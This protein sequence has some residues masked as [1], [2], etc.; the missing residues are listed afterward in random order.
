[1]R[2]WVR[3]EK[4]FILTDGAEKRLFH[5]RFTRFY[6]VVFLSLLAGSAFAQGGMW[7][8][9]LLDKNID[10]MRAMGFQ[11]TAEDVYSVNNASLKDAVIL[12]GGGCSGAIISKDGLL[13]T[14]H[15]CGYGDLQKLSSVE[16]DYLTHGYK[17][18]NRSQ[19]LP[20]PGLKV[21]FLEY[22][23]D[24]TKEI[25]K[26][27]RGKDDESKR[28]S[29]IEKN[30]TN[31]LEQLNKKNPDLI[32]EI[33]PLFY[34]NQYFV[35][36]YKIYNDIRLVVAPPSSI[37][38]FGGD[39]DNWEWPR[40]TGD[41]MLFRIY[42]DK[43]NNPAEYA[44]T[45]V[46]YKPKKHFKISIKG[47]NEGDFA[48]VYGYPARSNSFLVSQEVEEIALR[49]DP[50][51]VALRGKRLDILNG[52]MKNN[53]TIRIK[54]ASKYA[55]IA[56]AWKKWTG[57]SLGLKRFEAV[58]KKQQSEQKFR[59]WVKSDSKR[60]KMYGH[61]LP[62]FESIYARLSPL[63][64]SVDYYQQGLMG[65]ESFRFA[66][67]LMRY[68]MQRLDLYTELTPTQAEML[69]L[70]AND[71]F[72]DYDERVDRALM[73]RM[74]DTY[75]SEVP[76]A[77]MLPI[78][79]T[80]LPSKAQLE[81]FV[82]DVFA[83]SIFTSSDRMLNWLSLAPEQRKEQLGMDKLW[84]FVTK[85]QQEYDE[86]VDKPQRQ[87]ADYMRLLY[88]Q[89]V[90]GLQAMEPDRHMPADANFTMRVSYGLVQG[91]EPRDAV[92]Y[93]HYTTLD[94]V[95]EKASRGVD[96]YRIPDRLRKLY[97]SK[98]SLDIWPSGPMPTCFLASLQ[99]T[100]GNSGSPV[101]NARGELI[102]LNFDRVWEGTMS[103]V[104]FDKDR[105]RNI[106]VDIRYVIFLIKHYA[107]AD[108][109]LSE[110]EIVR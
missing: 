50:R 31:L 11:L 47:V 65:I 108:Y 109:L 84:A 22:M 5:M 37:G 79:K 90:A 105:C 89:Y 6:F 42:A 75:I 70:W 82:S 57:E 52:F 40:H 95:I 55:G 48:M 104:M 102:G 8:P 85:M 68:S 3:A 9:T 20:C 25:L 72:K 56:N 99:T 46:P 78:F 32:Y 41:Y 36:A 86:L 88:R 49:T 53:D 27:V 15:H 64:L 77:D 39:L 33:S 59:Q 83:S 38:K 60:R 76:E 14:N 91:Y 2:E 54:Y 106:A 97:D 45:N 28:Q 71:F 98:T 67:T 69:R 13:L 12:F 73:L 23:E 24:V 30:I 44:A 107:Q 74:L 58:D 92:S 7:I 93:R 4:A 63:L 43:D 29:K 80:T 34:G 66:T 96:D 21:T 101:L 16:N 110:L 61:I 51:R 35:Y 18:S 81:V 94:G 1:M 10:E 17:A 100:G 19:E 87:L 26:G 62:R 103:D